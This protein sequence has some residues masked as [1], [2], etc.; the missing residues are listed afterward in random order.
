MNFR[1]NLSIFH[2]VI[3]LVLYSLV[4][5]LAAS[6]NLRF[7]ELKMQHYLKTTSFAKRYIFCGNKI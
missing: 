6:L 7:V 2:S 1:T 3:I 5:T 4:V